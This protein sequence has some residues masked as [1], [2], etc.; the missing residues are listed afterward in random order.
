MNF[1]NIALVFAGGGAG[2]VI[3]YGLGVLAQ[4][5]SFALPVSTFVANISACAIFA[6]AVAAANRQAISADMRLLVL[7]GFCGGLSTFSTFGYETWMLIRQDMLAAAILNITLS[8]L[9]GLLMF[10]VLGR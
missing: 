9:L 8:T 3:R 5:M 1:T 6:I 10:Y 4:R 2:S 7:A